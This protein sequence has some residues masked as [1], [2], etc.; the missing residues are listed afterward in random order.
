MSKFASCLIYFMFAFLASQELAVAQ[1]SFVPPAG[2]A[3]GVRPQYSGPLPYAG[4]SVNFYTRIYGET[5]TQTF[6]WGGDIISVKYGTC[7]KMYDSDFEITGD[8]CS[9]KTLPPLGICSITVHFTRRAPG[10]RLA[11]LSCPWKYTNIP[12]LGG[13]VTTHLWAE[14][15]PGVDPDPDPTPAPS[16]T[17]FPTP[18]ATPIPTPNANPEPPKCQGTIK[19]SIIRVDAQ[20]L[21]EV[22][23]I[24]GAAFVLNYSTEN[25]RGYVAESNFVNRKLCFNP[26]GWTLSIQHYFD[27]GQRR[28]FKGDGT[29]EAK[30]FTQL[31]PERLMIVSSDGSEVYI[32][33][34][35]GKHLE[36][37]RALTGATKY[38][39]SYGASGKLD[40]IVDEVGHQTI[41]SRDDYSV[42]IQTPFGQ[43]TSLNLNGE[44]QISSITNPQN[45]TY[46]MTYKPNTDLLETFVKP[47]GQTSYFIYDSEGK[48]R[49]DLGHGGDFSG[50]LRFLLPT[51]RKLERYTAL[52]RL[53]TYG[54]R[55][56]G[57]VTFRN[58]REP[59]GFE[60][61]Y[62]EGANGF[63]SRNSQAEI[64]S[65]S[66]HDPKFG[67]LLSYI[68]ESYLTIEGIRSTTRYSKSV[69]PIPQ[70]PNYFNF[71]TI[72]ESM[73]IDGESP[74]EV[75]TYNNANKMF[76]V[77][78]AE[79][80]VVKTIIDAQERP[81]S[82]QLGN[83]LPI[84]YSYNGAGLLTNVSQGSHT[85]Q[86]NYYNNLGLLSRTVNATNSYVDFTYDLAGRIVKKE[87]SN[88]SAFLMA[89]DK[90]GNLKKITPPNRPQH[91]FFLNGFEL[92]ETYRPPEVTGLVAKDTIYSYNLDRQITNIVRPDQQ[93]A[94]FK[95]DVYSGLLRNIELA[96]GNYI[97][98][99]KSDSNLASEITSPDG[100]KNNFEYYG[101]FL[102][103]ETYTNLGNSYTIGTISYNF[104]S[105]H[106]I[107]GRAIDK[108]GSR[109]RE[110]RYLYNKDGMLKQV[111]DLELTYTYPSGRLAS[112]K[113][114]KI[115]DRREYDTSGRLALY[116]AIFDKDGY[117]HKTLYSY[118]LSRD[119]QGRIIR[120]IE[121]VSGKTEIYDYSYDEVGRL[122]E[123]LQNGRRYS[124]YFYDPNGNRY[125]GLT[126]GRHFTASFDNQDR[127]QTYN[128]N[129]AISNQ[130]FYNEN[131]DTLLVKGSG[132][133]AR[134]YSYD[135]M[136]MISSIGSGDSN[137]SFKYDGL[138]RIVQ[139]ESSFGKI[140]R[141]YQDDLK[142]AA[143]YSSRS[144]DYKVFNYGTGINVPDYLVWGEKNYRYVLDHLGSP[145]LVVDAKLGTIVQKIDYNDLGEIVLDTNPGFQP[146]GFAGG[147]YDQMA[148]LVKF[149]TR[150]YDPGMGRWIS[151][152]P[153]RFDGG[154]GN[155]YAYVAND[156]INGIDPSGLIII[157]VNN[158]IPAW[159]K[160]TPIYKELNSSAS[161]T[162]VRNRSGSSE[163]DAGQTDSVGPWGIFQTIDID[164]EQSKKT[165][166]SKT[167]PQLTD[168]E[169]SIL[170]EFNHARQYQRH[171]F[172]DQTTEDGDNT[173]LTELFRES[174][175]YKK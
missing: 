49:K 26:N 150:Y 36:T 90:N 10:F 89:Y 146:Y 131:G 111:G 66:D 97:F 166:S 17:P 140:Y 141:I 80:A 75:V 54:S 11:L 93:S 18:T 5:P 27:L 70:A 164:V 88:G 152:D 170:H 32:F 48:L 153:I 28:L 30:N 172:Q 44:G 42:K 122:K 19:G 130:Y 145:R 68:S 52:G 39:F 62:G 72:T 65:V 104:D 98:S 2:V 6:G 147:I 139:T 12:D 4:G 169:D 71:D 109:K 144:G 53:T 92:V 115:E 160:N 134:K 34:N 136:G 60:T 99:Y 165:G 163:I 58:R 151:K 1:L 133:L 61:E 116:E 155:L 96:R 127:I 22:V 175:L 103:S 142:I 135:A 9:G 129:S 55:S 95:Y 161:L 105:Q 50:F 154:D 91:Q 168:L 56:D 3:D 106:R 85:L 110:S 74:A 113:L 87:F 173:L 112:T 21:G 158:I 125:Q 76:I 16:P 69:N 13:I 83:D 35:Q 124:K 79:G 94:V 57:S 171:F 119:T 108:V 102:K 40:Q 137:I 100:I 45:E 123:V 23:P 118:R 126:G 81:L 64:G 121:S 138:G 43:V 38:T 114:D 132:K 167:C 107:S 59:S 77:T 84:V 24:V 25:S 143:E 162:F 148:K 73:S 101:P 157:D 67:E 128:S 7:S 156:P 14:A 47:E 82:T 31:D 86:S 78:S 20:S 120:K 117:R 46:R 8:T 33:D 41:F 51:E 174:L 15:L 37:K 149:G 159:I 29:S 63:Y